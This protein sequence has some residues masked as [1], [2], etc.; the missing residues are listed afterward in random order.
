M[1]MKL[2][3]EAKVKKKEEEKKRKGVITGADVACTG[4]QEMNSDNKKL[5]TN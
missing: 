1:K 3:N 5:K 4:L 2:A